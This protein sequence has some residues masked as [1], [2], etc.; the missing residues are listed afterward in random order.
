LDDAVAAGLNAGIE[1][2]MNQVSHLFKLKGLA[3]YR[4]S[5]L[6]RSRLVRGSIIP[7]KTSLW[8][9]GLPMDV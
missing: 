4:L 1:V 3:D 8:I 6:Y 9:W 7:M 5:T 2:L